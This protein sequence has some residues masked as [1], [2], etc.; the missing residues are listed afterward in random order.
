MLAAI[1]C[2]INSAQAQLTAADVQ[3]VIN[4]ATK[5]AN[6]IAPNSVIAVADREGY[7]LGVWNVRGGEPVFWRSRARSAKLGRQLF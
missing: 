4:Q 1:C 7:V 6:K 5:R 2:L 3:R